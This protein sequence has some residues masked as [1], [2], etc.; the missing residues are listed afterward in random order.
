M[1]QR[2]FDLN[3]V[4]YNFQQVQF[5]NTVIGDKHGFLIVVDGCLIQLYEVGSW[6]VLSD[7]LDT[8]TQQFRR[9]QTAQEMWFIP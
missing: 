2:V 3:M 7:A 8:N 6:T 5:L 9:L 4:T 1:S